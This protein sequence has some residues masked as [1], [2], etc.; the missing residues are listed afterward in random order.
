MHLTLVVRM[1]KRMQLKLVMGSH[2]CAIIQVLF[3]YCWWIL[4][5]CNDWN[6]ALTCMVPWLIPN[7][8]VVRNSRLILKTNIFLS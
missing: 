8:N 1:Y 4:S 2:W 7:S 5:T 6:V 3:D